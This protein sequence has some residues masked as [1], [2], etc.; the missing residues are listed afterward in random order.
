MSRPSLQA[1]GTLDSQEQSQF[2]RGQLRRLVNSQ[3]LAE[4]ARLRSLLAFLVEQKLLGHADQIKESV[5]AVEVFG[6]DAAFD[7]RIDS[8][9]RVQIRNLRR[10]LEEYYSGEGQDDLVR[11][12]L[13]KGSYVPDFEVQDIRTPPGVSARKRVRL[14]TAAIVA[15]ATICMLAAGAWWMGVRV[16]EPAPGSLAV[17][18]F[19]ILGG[20]AESE[21]LSHGMADELMAM[22][23]TRPGLRVAARSSAFQFKGKHVDARDVARQLQVTAV[24]EG[25]I[26]SI[27]DRLKV[28]AQLIG[29]RD[30]LSLWSE[31]YDGD[32]RETPAMLHG[33]ASGVAAALKVASPRIAPHTTDPETQDLYLKG[34][35]L[36]ARSDATSREK[37]IALLEAAALRDAHYAPALA[38]FAAA[39]ANESFHSAPRRQQWAG[40]ARDAA[41]GAIAADETSVKA[42]YALAWVNFSYYRDWPAAEEGFRRALALNPHH[43]GSHNLYALGLTT[44]GR[45]AEAIVEA[46]RARELDPAVYTVSTDLG[47]VYYLSRRFAD[48]EKFARSVMDM[49]RGFGQVQMLL[50]VCLA[51]ERRYAEALNELRSLAATTD[52]DEV[53]GRYGFIL[54]RAGDRASALECVRKISASDDDGGDFASALALIH[55]GL[56]ERDRAFEWLFKAA[57]RRETAAVF[58]G[59]EP[60]LDDLR[61]DPRFA[62]LRQRLGL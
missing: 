22:L 28:H 48:G 30:G 37:G 61:S 21:Y 16:A 58:A 15:A 6:R 12:L 51:G 49:E 47:L 46:R 27:G 52:G 40:K 14:K 20:G 13:P 4:S 59:V 35:Y 18:P 38:A 8:I 3:L 33:I 17:L 44:R 60:M 34:V 24:L 50:G 26:Q 56:G 9:V 42:H 62:V 23:V 32:R 43:A 11:I 57:D 39:A 19:S 5:I 7:P 1:S 10:K 31:T 53:Q 25:S 55:A 36:R 41:R 54:A 29:G 45:F 2:V